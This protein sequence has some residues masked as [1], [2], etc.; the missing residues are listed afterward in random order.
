ML[1]ALLSLLFAMV[2]AVIC[3]VLEHKI[4]L[5]E[6]VEKAI[7]AFKAGWVEDKI[8]GVLIQRDRLEKY[9]DRD[10][11]FWDVFGR[12]AGVLMLLAAGLASDRLV[13]FATGAHESVSLWKFVGLLLYI[14]AFVSGVSVWWFC[15]KKS[16][17]AIGSRILKLDAALDDLIAKL[18]SI[19]P[20]RGECME[21]YISRRR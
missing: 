5:S 16:P 12:L 10:A 6:K 7:D 11:L 2:C 3:G 17:G 4:R 20:F 18:K 21:Q 15:Q 13:L 14:M 1:T 8:T 19:D 9:Y